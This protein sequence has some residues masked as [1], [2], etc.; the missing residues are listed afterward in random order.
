MGP[1]ADVYATGL[2]GRELLGAMVPADLL[3]AESLDP[4]VVSW[5]DEVEEV[6][7]KAV[8]ECLLRALAR[9]PAKRLRPRSCGCVSR[10]SGW[11]P[12]R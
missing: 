8:R 3:D 4:A 7:P 9:N 11:C 5:P 1:A 2:L 6:V 10:R 12:G